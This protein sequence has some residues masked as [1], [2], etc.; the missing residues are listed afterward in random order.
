MG[1]TLPTSSLCQRQTDAIQTFTQSLFYAPETKETKPQPLF[2][3]LASLNYLNQVDLKIKP[4]D[5]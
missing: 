1:R 3:L 4:F 5:Y 2:S